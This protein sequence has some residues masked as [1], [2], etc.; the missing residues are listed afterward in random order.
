L[1]H[2]YG[3]AVRLVTRNGHDLADRFPLAAS[4]IEA[5]PVKSCVIDGEAIVCDDNGLAVFDL[6]RGHGRNGQAILCAFDLLELDSKDLRRASLEERKHTLANV[7]FREREGI[8]FNQHYDG[9]GEIVFKQASSV[10]RASCRNGSARPIAPGDRL[11]GSRSRI[12][13]RRPCGGSK[14]KIGR[15]DGHATGVAMRHSRM[16]ASER[17]CSP[18]VVIRQ[19]RPRSCARG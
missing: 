15:S 14:R 5:L 8:I 19:S 3:R 16:G 4:A 10:A 13:P 9:D 18:G 6:I 7:L 1:A 17:C 12:L 11:T 2:R